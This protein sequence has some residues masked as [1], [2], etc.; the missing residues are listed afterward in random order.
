MVPALAYQ[1][2]RVEMTTDGARYRRAVA[3]LIEYARVAAERDTRIYEAH[4]AG[5]PKAEIARLIDTSWA[6]VDRA[7]RDMEAKNA[8]ESSGGT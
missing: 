8:S 7:V 2:V 1:N 3:S 5:V 6:T 4:Q